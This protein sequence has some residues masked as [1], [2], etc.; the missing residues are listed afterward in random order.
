[1]VYIKTDFLECTVI[2][3]SSYNDI[4]KTLHRQNKKTPG[5]S[6]ELYF[7]LNK[8][9]FRK[10]SLDLLE[11]CFLDPKQTQ[12]HRQISQFRL[13]NFL[14]KFKRNYHYYYYLRGRKDSD[15]INNTYLNT[16]AV[17]QLFLIAGI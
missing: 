17:E 2:T 6:L 15:S 14:K 12:D 7:I 5:G 3:L 9:Y 8:T 4:S 10:T 13:Q 11:Y 1:M 16:K